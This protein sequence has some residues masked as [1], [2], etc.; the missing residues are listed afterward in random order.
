MHAPIAPTRPCQRG[1]R[2]KFTFALALA[3]I[4]GI[5]GLVSFGCSDSA[6]SAAPTQQASNVTPGE[7]LLAAVQKTSDSD[8]VHVELT[9]ALSDS[10]AGPQQITGSGDVDFG[11]KKATLTLQA[12]GMNVDAVT[13]DSVLYLHAGLLGAGW[14]R[15]TPGDAGDAG[16]LLADGFID[17]A[18]QLSL[19]EQ[20]G[21]DVT[22]VGE[23]TINGQETT[24]YRAVVDVAGLAEKNG[25]DASR[26]EQ[27][28]DAGITTV[29]VDAWAGAD[30]RLARMSLELGG[31]GT[32]GILAGGTVKVTADYSDYGKAVDVTVPP[33]DQV[34]D[35]SASNLG[36]LLSVGSGL[37]S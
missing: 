1:G 36:Q 15:V 22:R 32:S 23:E 26:L 18:Q 20:T 30:G 17:P 9:M 3:A 2:A 25:A 8:T 34:Q 4:V 5:F 14:Y 33:T 35:L 11:A 19:L 7:L 10:Q 13:A 29:P 21:A 27:L 16:A 24:H 37:G 31:A 12:L 6:S 28:K